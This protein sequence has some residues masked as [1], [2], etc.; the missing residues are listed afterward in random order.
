M[1]SLPPWLP[2]LPSPQSKRWW[3]TQSQR[4]RPPIWCFLFVFFATNNDK[5]DV[6]ELAY[7]QQR[8]WDRIKDSGE[9]KRSGL[10]TYVHDN[11]LTNVNIVDSHCS[12]DLEYLTVKCRPFFL[13]HEFAAVMVT[14]V[15]IT[16]NANFNTGQG[17]ILHA[18]NSNQT[19]P[20]DTVQTIAGN[21]KNSLISLQ[22]SRDK[23]LYSAARAR[24]RSIKVAKTVQK[25]S[26]KEEIRST[27]HK[28]TLAEYLASLK[29]TK[30]VFTRHLMLMLC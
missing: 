25:Q 9:T 24:V 10:C 28:T 6:A 22:C 23:A 20:T 26:T 16:L 17:Y 13:L 19:T 21:F 3:P 2:L 11:W 15:Y 12:P 4:L 27:S 30:A 18:I 14:V 1:Q 8:H 5:R 7:T 29:T